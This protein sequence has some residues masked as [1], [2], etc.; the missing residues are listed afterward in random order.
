MEIRLY[1]DGE[2][3]TCH[4]PVADDLDGGMDELMSDV[5]YRQAVLLDADNSQTIALT[6]YHLSTEGTTGKPPAGAPE[7]LIDVFIGNEPAEPVGA[8]GIVEVMDLL[9]RWAPAVQASL[10]CEATSSPRYSAKHGA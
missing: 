2:W 4:H 3:T 8:A 5:G 7:Y 1:Q 6:V 10:A 9:G